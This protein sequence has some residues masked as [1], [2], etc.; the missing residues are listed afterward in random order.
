MQVEVVEELVSHEGNMSS[1]RGGVVVKSEEV[2]Q[3]EVRQ[4]M[5]CVSEELVESHSEEEKEC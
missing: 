5:E 3:Q 4:S 1:V 2:Y